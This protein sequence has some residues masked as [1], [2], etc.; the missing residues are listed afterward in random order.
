M[1]C[2]LAEQLKIASDGLSTDRFGDVVDCHHHVVDEQPDVALA[3]AKIAHDAVDQLGPKPARGDQID[4]NAE[5]V[6]ELLLNIEKLEKTDRGVEL[7]QKID[8]ALGC[9]ITACP[10]A[11]DADRADRVRRAQDR[12]GCGQA[13]AQLLGRLWAGGVARDCRLLPTGKSQHKRSN[14][15]IGSSTIGASGASAW[16]GRR[17]QA[18]SWLPELGTEPECGGERWDGGGEEHDLGAE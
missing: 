9:L 7:D 15:A 4:P 14:A 2:G 10:G 5:H 8:V 3:H 12:Q 11:E 16:A 17:R 6:L 1:R 13:G 18:G